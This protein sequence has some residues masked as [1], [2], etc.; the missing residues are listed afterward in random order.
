MGMY[1]L[2]DHLDHVL[3]EADHAYRTRGQV[4]A[5]VKLHEQRAEHGD[6]I[7][8][9]TAIIVTWIQLA[10]RI[11]HAARMPI[12]RIDLAVDDPQREH[13]EEALRH[14]AR[15]ARKLVSEELEGRGIRPDHNLVLL[16]AG[17]REELD[18]LETTQLL[19]EIIVSGEGPDAERQLVLRE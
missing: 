10:E 6:R 3:D 11:I 19:W 18:Q 12:D 2:Y 8:I 13:D 16:T 1:L 14:R 17:L 7:I 4:Q 5:Y 9:R 15:V